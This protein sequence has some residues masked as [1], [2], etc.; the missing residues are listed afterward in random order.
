MTSVHPALAPRVSEQVSVA[1]RT[2]T[3]IC[4]IYL[5]SLKPALACAYQ[6]RAAAHVHPLPLQWAVLRHDRKAVVGGERC[7]AAGRKT[8]KEASEHSRHFVII[9]SNISRRCFTAERL[10]T[11]ERKPSMASCRGATTG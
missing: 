2:H 8:P 7:D 10:D 11:A 3:N 5:L 6:A 1:M 9:L 4:R